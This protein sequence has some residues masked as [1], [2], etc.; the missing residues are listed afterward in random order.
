MRI[1][2]RRE[3]HPEAGTVVDWVPTART[4]NAAKGAPPHPVPVSFL[5]RDHITGVLA[6][7]AEDRPHRAYTCAAV[8]VPGRFDESRLTAALTSFLR[9]HPGLRC[10]FRAD[11]EQLT[12]HLIVAG[13]VEL[14][15]EHPVVADRDI[16]AHIDARL[17]RSA[18]FD[19]FPAVV[20]GAVVR[21]DGFDLYFGI[22]HAFGDGS[23][24]AI[25][26]ADILDRYHGGAG[27]R[28][29]SHI[30]HVATE[31]ALAGQIAER[32]AEV[33]E[34]ADALR[35]TDGRLPG[36]A[37]DLGLEQT[38]AGPV[39]QR[40]R[41]RRAQLAD[42]EDTEA[43][44]AVAAAAG[45]GFTAAV[46]AALALADRELGGRDHF[47]TATV[48]STRGSAEH[49]LAQGWYCNFAPVAF[50]VQG[51][52]LREVIGDAAAGL[53][54][55]RRLSAL[56]AHA[57]LATLIGTGR[58]DPS[59]AGSPQM[60]SYLDFRWFP[61]QREL[62]DAVLFTG[63]GRTRNAS[64][65]ISRDHD[66]LWIATQCP[67]NPV[68]GAAVT[69]YFDTVRAHLTAALTAPVAIGLGA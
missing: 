5:Q 29:G 45:T 49:Q 30:D 18:V 19:S 54:R 21:H 64:Q 69:R 28:S 47:A 46:Y 67:D 56:P 4:I 17:A 36:F 8:Q 34:W 48:L 68:A 50:P 58:V 39:P 40:V 62:S 55:A 43:I 66:G 33:A 15:T 35:P 11:G 38:A 13:D 25:G 16:A 42:A 2:A 65:W 52:T 57:V 3:W 26:I 31:Y 20:F 9:D 51:A 53:S 59:V 63:E 7:R 37:L 24:Q 41:I 44:A 14:T 60:V 6:A 22:D 27:F 10:V 32:D 1:V 23:S 12:R 61:A